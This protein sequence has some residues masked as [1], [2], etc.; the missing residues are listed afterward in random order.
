MDFTQLQNK[1]SF[2]EILI[3]DITADANLYVYMGLLPSRVGHMR[4]VRQLDV[5]VVRSFE[6]QQ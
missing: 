3:F 6:H 5:F 1:I 2:D 4:G